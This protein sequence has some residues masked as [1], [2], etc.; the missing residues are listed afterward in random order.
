LLAAAALAEAIVGNCEV[1]LGEARALIPRDPEPDNAW[2]V[3]EAL[4]YC[5][6][7]ARAQKLVRDV[8][9][10]FPNATAW[11]ATIVPNVG[12]GRAAASRSSALAG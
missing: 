2:I 12:A 10:R 1:A 11:N 5:G 9:E 7:A 3:A 8:S 6:D 4:A